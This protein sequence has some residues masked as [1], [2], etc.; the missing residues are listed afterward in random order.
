MGS[1]SK[2]NL[3][4]LL[5]RVPSTLDKGDKLRAYHQLKHLSD[6]Y[7]IM[8]ICLDTESKW[9][10]LENILPLC[11]EVKIFR[12][13]KMMRVW[14]LF[15]NI[16][17]SKPF[18]V[19]YFYNSR[20]KKKILTEIRNFKPDHIY[21]Q[22]IR[23][24][25]YVKNLHEYPKTL[26]YMDAFSK[27]IERRIDHVSFL[28]KI[29]FKAERSRLVKYES[30]IFEYF[31]HK[32]IIS[33]VDREFIYHNKKSEIEIVPN[34]IDADFFD[35]S[36]KSNNKSELLFTGNMSYA[37]NVKAAEFIINQLAPELSNF[38]ITI[39][40]ANPAP[41]IQKGAS[42]QI[43]VTGWVEDIKNN[44]R[45]S[46]VFIAPMFIGTGLQ[47]K[48]LEAMAMGIPCITTDL[49]NKPL[50]AKDGKHILIANNKSEFIQKINELKSDLEL[51]KRIAKEGQEFVKSNF[52]W[53]VST[54]KLKSIMKK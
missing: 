48:L 23:T 35:D 15:L 28:E 37:P 33:E 6:H 18:Q 39:C 50:G 30:L 12:I 40:G 13:T 27:G 29:V 47:N 41:V 20:L 21:S 36:D 31:E 32:T 53:E 45:K 16:F 1:D 49:A 19:A 8:L 26:D 24:S 11:K 14:Q 10:D 38:H 5:S 43:D 7:N 4:M 34:G 54:D 42:E 44:Y 25:E 51:Y 3:V 52:S 2:P 22:L 17:S 9:H 46:W